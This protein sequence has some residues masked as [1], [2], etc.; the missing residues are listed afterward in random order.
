[1][2]KGCVSESHKVT[3]G[4][5]IEGKQKVGGQTSSNEMARKDMKH[6]GIGSRSRMGNLAVGVAS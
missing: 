3:K 2:H 4:Q 1:L 6:V 5:R